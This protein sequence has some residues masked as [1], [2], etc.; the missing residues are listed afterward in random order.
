MASDMERITQRS[1]ALKELAL[2]RRELH[3]EAVMLGTEAVT[4]ILY[5]NGKTWVFHED[6]AGP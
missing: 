3:G 2:P 4:A 5:W 6:P 1:P